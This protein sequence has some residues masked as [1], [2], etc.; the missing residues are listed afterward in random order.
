MESRGR[1]ARDTWTVVGVVGVGLAL[2]GLAVWW[3]Q[4]PQRAAREVEGCIGECRP[5][6]TLSS[7]ARSFLHN[8][9]GWSEMEQEF[10][11]AYCAVPDGGDLTQW[12]RARPQRWGEWVEWWEESRTSGASV[13]AVGIAGVNRRRGF[14]ETEGLSG[15][16]QLDAAGRRRL[17]ARVRSI[18]VARASS[19]V[20]KMREGD[21]R[22][23]RQAL[24]E[25]ASPL[26]EIEIG[27]AIVSDIA[28]SATPVDSGPAREA[29]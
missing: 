23:A 6:G 5:L 13:R 18:L 27:D 19:V 17:A 29:E 20:S 9:C 26:V 28:E 25:V 15:M 1:E 3:T 12:L 2:S 4:M 21:W 7:E 10:Y 24:R 14:G 11:S 22:G 8:E 16:R